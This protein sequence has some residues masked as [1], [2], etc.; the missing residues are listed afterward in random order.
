MALGGPRQR[1]RRKGDQSNSWKVI[2]VRDKEK[3][4]KRAYLCLLLLH[5]AQKFKD[6]CSGIWEKNRKGDFTIFLTK[7]RAYDKKNFLTANSLK[8]TVV[9][10]KCANVVAGARSV[11]S[12]AGTMQII[13]T[14]LTSPGQRWWHLNVSDGSRRDETILHMLCIL[15]GILYILM[16]GL[17][18]EKVKVL[19]ARGVMKDSRLGVV[20][21][22][23]CGGIDKAKVV[24]RVIRLGAY[25]YKWFYTI[26]SPFL[27]FYADHHLHHHDDVVTPVFISAIFWQWH[28][29][30]SGSGIL[31]QAV[32]SSFWQWELSNQQWEV[33][34]GSGNFLTS[35]GNALCI[36][37]PTSSSS[38]PAPVSFSQV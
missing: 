7:N 37:F 36:L 10:S 33:P 22:M 31:L 20:W 12:S 14:A 27:P 32:G 28:H 26:S 13:N 4:S 19:G 16:E 29:F 6:N 5:Q 1:P 25:K 38:Y 35:S 8:S 23:L 18:L 30:S 11:K 24:S 21:M 9:A 2:P 15:N 3:D 34:S 17:K